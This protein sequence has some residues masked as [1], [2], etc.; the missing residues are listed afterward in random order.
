MVR[1]QKLSSLFYLGSHG[2]DSNQSRDCHLF[3]N[4]HD[5][6]ITDIL[7]RGFVGVQ[8]YIMFEYPSQPFD[9]HGAFG[10]YGGGCSSSV[11]VS[12][13]IVR[14]DPLADTA[15]KSASPAFTVAL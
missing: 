13:P 7:L 14:S 11:L 8:A 12:V 9:D 6:K 3:S 5:I 2:L 4:T 10:A 1:P 15:N